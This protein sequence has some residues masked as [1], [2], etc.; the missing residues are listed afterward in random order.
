MY[1]FVHTCEYLEGLDSLESNFWIEENKLLTNMV[2]KLALFGNSLIFIK[3]LATVPLRFVPYEVF[4]SS[5]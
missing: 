1:V 3:Q 2:Q 5:V 4:K